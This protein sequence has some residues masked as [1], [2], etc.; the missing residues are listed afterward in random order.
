MEKETQNR[1]TYLDLTITKEH[2][3]LTFGIYRKPTTTDSITHNDSCHP[4]E[5][6]K[7]A[8]NYLTNRM[9]IYPLTQTNTD[10]E[11]TIIKKDIKE[12]WIPTIDY[13]S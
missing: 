7:S 4:S 10:Q 3:K 6:K 5:H 11:Q 12:K 1:T 13:T 8:T 9:K 2:H